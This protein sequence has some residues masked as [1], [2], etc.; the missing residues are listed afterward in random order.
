MCF[1]QEVR[2]TICQHQGLLENSKVRFFFPSALSIEQLLEEPP[3][4]L[5]RLEEHIAQLQFAVGLVNQD[6]FKCLCIHTSSLSSGISSFRRNLGVSRAIP[7]V[8]NSS[9]PAA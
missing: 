5:Q 9:N 2:G 6:S 3:T 7:M 1:R 8:R 4:Q